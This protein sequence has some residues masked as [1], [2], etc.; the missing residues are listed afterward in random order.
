MCTIHRTRSRRESW[1][2]SIL[3]VERERGNGQALLG[4]TD[5]RYAGRIIPPI[6][7]RARGQTMSVVWRTDDPSDFFLLKRSNLDLANKRAVG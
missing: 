1:S 3:G 6:V 4:R 5:L 2:R 7:G